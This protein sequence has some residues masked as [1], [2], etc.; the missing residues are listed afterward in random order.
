MTGEFSCNLLD[1]AWV[2]QVISELKKIDVK[3]KS[4]E[5]TIDSSLC[6]FGILPRQQEWPD[7]N[8]LAFLA[9]AHFQQKYPN[10]SSKDYKLLFDYVAFNQPILTVALPHYI[11]EGFIVLSEYQEIS[12]FNPSLFKILKV[13][14][15]NEL[16]YE[17]EQF[18]YHVDYTAKERETIDVL[19]KKFINYDS[20]DVWNIQ[21]VAEIFFKKNGRYDK[22]WSGLVMNT[23]EQLFNLI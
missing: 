20:I 4:L 21:R 10:F 7:E 1:T 15:L 16:W 18:F 2:D 5:I 19:P 14:D 23:P 6:R 3:Y 13:L 11:H 8:V 17:E 9:V 12:N 22:H